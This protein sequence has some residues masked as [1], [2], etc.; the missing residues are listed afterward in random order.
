MAHGRH[1]RKTVARVGHVKVRDEHV[2]A[3]RGDLSQ[4]R[5][6]AIGTDHLKPFSF[7][8]LRHHGADSSVIVH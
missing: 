7:Q 3:F 6:H 2:K 5:C 4:S 8:P 1:N